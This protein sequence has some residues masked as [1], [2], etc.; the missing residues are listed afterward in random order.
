MANENLKITRRLMWRLRH[1]MVERNII[2]AAELTRRLAD[3][4]FSIHESQ[5][6][7]IL[8]DRPVEIKTDLLDAL[9]EVLQCNIQDI[10][11]SDALDPTAGTPNSSGT[12]STPKPA[13]A[14]RPRK[15]STTKKAT[16][17][18]TQPAIPRISV[19]P[20]I[21]KKADPA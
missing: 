17:I 11:R 10:L 12:T 3:I 19:V 16:G 20:S 9:L 5:I 8:K 13:P 14:P 21:I 7:R 2:T 15:S 18:A 6:S 4:G 1:M